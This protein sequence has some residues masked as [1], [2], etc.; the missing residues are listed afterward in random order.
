MVL[1]CFIF[2][3]LVAALFLILCIG[4]HKVDAK[5]VYAVIA[6]AA[7]AAQFSIGIR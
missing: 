5:V 2:Y 3:T 6:V 7:A 4:E 1:F